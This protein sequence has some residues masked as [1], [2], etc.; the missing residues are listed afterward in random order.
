MS[1]KWIE[2]EGGRDWPSQHGPHEEDQGGDSD[3]LGG[4]S[5]VAPVNVRGQSV[6]QVAGWTSRTSG[7]AEVSACSQAERAGPC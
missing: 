7:S 5:G 3:E 2:P 4:C 1:L 6:E